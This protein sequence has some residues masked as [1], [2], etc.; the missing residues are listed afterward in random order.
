MP[1]CWPSGPPAP[2]RAAR[3]TPRPAGRRT[4]CRR[5]PPAPA[6]PAAAPRRATPRSG[7]PAVIVA[8]AAGCPAAMPVLAASRAVA[9]LVVE[10]VGQGE[11]QVLAV[12]VQLPPGELERLLLGAHHARVGAQVAQGRHPALA[13]DPFGVLA[14]HAEHADHG[15][16]VVAQRAVGE[17]VVGLLRV[18][19]ALE[20]QQQRL[21]PGRLAGGEHAVD[22]RADVVPDLLP[23]LAGRPA[24][25]PRV[26]AAQ[27][28][29][30]VGG[31]AEERQ[32][33]PPGHPHREAGGQQ[34]AH[35]RL[36]ALR[37]GP[38]RPERGGGP[39]HRGQ[40][41]A[42]LLV[43]GEHPG[44]ARASARHLPHPPPAVLSSRP[45][46]PLARFTASRN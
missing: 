15:A 29:A 19:G 40:V 26:L 43:G 4:G 9:P 30:P 20:E 31:V 3:A 22:A 25:R 27:R 23:H 32:L 37:P 5:G 7:S 35:R 34:D 2:G 6:R 8:G 41:T 36:Q 13:D 14:D 33:R 11:R 1:P 45:G 12:Q 44:L 42:D 24:E 28:V 16:V 21:V 46:I 18:A 17:G 10:Q 39:V 38:R